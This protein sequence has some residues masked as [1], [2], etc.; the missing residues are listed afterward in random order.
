MREAVSPKFYLSLAVLFLLPA[1]SFGQAGSLDP[2]FGT[3][4]VLL[5]RPPLLN[6]DAGVGAIGSL[7]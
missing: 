2:S 5:T 4:G 1:L 7:V 3:N 6:V